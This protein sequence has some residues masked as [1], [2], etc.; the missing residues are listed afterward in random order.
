MIGNLTIDKA[1]MNISYFL[2]TIRIIADNN[3]RVSRGDFVRQ[4]AD[5]I[6]APASIGGKENRTPYNKSKL[7]RYFGF[8]D[9]EKTATQSF[10][11][12][13]NRGNRL[14]NYILEN[15]EAPADQ[16]YTIN[17]ENREDFI[18]IIFESVIFGSFGK[19]NCGAEQSNTD[20]EPPKIVFKTLLELGR[21]TAEEI[22]YVMFALNK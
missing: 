6:G 22:C 13:T 14:A 20:V 2:K 8:V 12:L 5:F 21:A 19:N 16:R 10:L 18:N 15:A 4:M 7:P 9:I 1:S 11:I 17:P 3:G